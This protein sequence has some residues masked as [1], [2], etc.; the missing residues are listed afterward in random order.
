MGTRHLI[1]V[2]S[3]G[4]Y[5]VAQYCQ[6]DGYP[7]G[8]GEA[9]SSFLRY[10]LDLGKLKR[11]LRKTKFLTGKEIDT[12]WVECGMEPGA[13]SV[14]M[15]IANTVERK[16]PGLSRSTG[17]DI[18]R[19]AQNGEAKELD[20]AL[21]FAADSLFCEWAYVVNLDSRKLEVYKGFNKE[22]L[23]PNERFYPLTAL[24]DEGYQPIKHLKSY[25]FS[26]L[27]ENT[28]TELEKEVS[29]DDE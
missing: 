22:P 18:L 5:K 6:W 21:T 8:Q 15:E 25:K 20:N 13:V 10:H 26:E 11:A 7:T 14:S 9:I 24:S 29:K 19:L 27:D 23:S 16:H 12:L 3:D 17:A 28:M 4:E 1:A 2:V